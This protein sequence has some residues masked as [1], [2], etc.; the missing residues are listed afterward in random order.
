[1]QVITLLT[2]YGIADS[3]VAEV[4]GAILKINPNVTIIDIS[5]DV[6]N[7]DIASGAFQLARA[8]SYFPEGT[9]HIGVVDPGVGSVRKSIIIKTRNMWLV[10]PDNGLLAPAADRLGIKQIWEI[11]NN[12]ILPKRV[13]D[14]FDGRDVFGPT[15]ALISKGVS[16]DVIGTEIHDIIRLSYSQPKVD[17]ESIHGNIIHIDGFGNAVTNITYETLEKIGVK[18][19]ASFKVTIN[20][21]SYDLPYVRRFSAVDEGELL[22]LVA[23]GGYLEISVNQGNAAKLLALKRGSKVNLKAL[24]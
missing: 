10:G 13:S 19:E 15:G 9:I 24:K 12:E 16:P 23:G 2:D 1:M 6:G 21:E 17:D 7:Y 5:H 14:V 11:T 22:L 18:G 4:K 8:V 3:Y 20:N